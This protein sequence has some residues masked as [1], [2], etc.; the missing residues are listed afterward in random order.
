M[1]LLPQ[2]NISNIYDILQKAFKADSF[3]GSDP[4]LMLI[5]YSNPNEAIEINCNP[6]LCCITDSIITGFVLEQC[7]K[8]N[9]TILANI[10]KVCIVLSYTLNLTNN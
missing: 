6:P 4:K 1:Q 3:G 10:L 2:K 9:D 7:K 8:N 5:K